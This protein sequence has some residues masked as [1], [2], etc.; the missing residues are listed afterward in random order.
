M[1]QRWAQKLPDEIN[2]RRNKTLRDR[3]RSRR[4]YGLSF[5]RFQDPS[6]KID[7]MKKILVSLTLLCSLAPALHAEE[8]M[9]LEQCYKLALGQSE[10]LL[11]QKEKILQFKLKARQAS[12]AIL[13]D[14]DLIY[15][16]FFQDTTGT[17]AGAGG[18]GGTLTR[19][20][21]PEAKI[22]GKQTVFSGFQEYYAVKGFRA[23]QRKEQL[24]YRRAEQLLYQETARAFY[25]VIQNQ[26]DLQNIRLTLS[27][28]DGR[29]K[30]LSSRMR[31][32]KSRSS[33]VRSVES[34]LASLRAEE[35]RLKGN[36]LIAQDLLAFL[37]GR[38]AQN[39]ILADTLPVP[40]ALDSEQVYLAR[41]SSRTDLASLREEVEVSRNQVKYMRGEFFPTVDLTGNYYLKR[42]GF[43]EAINWDVLLS[44][45]LPLFRGGENAAKLREAQSVL[46]WS[47]WNYRRFEREAASEI[48]RSYY[49]L[50]SSLAQGEAL[51]TAYEKAK[52]S[53]E[54]QVK[55]YRYGLVNNLEVLQS[56]NVL[57]AAKRDRDRT[58]IQNKIN[59]IQ[60][61]VSTE[62]LP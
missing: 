40:G 60:L 1:R 8:S 51:V 50:K 25:S 10:T 16:N 13:P 32:G 30:E 14:I 41:I 21:R 44:I 34:Q 31:L 33:E 48:R 46:H 55:E 59:T 6:H 37:I 5:T 19:S 39:V 3:P 42:V 54:E 56:M 61:K 20:E 4:E 43:Q 11:M 49:T 15:S 12:S 58:L 47:E 57:Q 2:V 53:Y 36:I 35:E 38:D 17:D 45:D 23:Q 7:P 22:Q 62:E 18:V 29:V 28:T 24:D 52:E 27:L 26:T 9:T